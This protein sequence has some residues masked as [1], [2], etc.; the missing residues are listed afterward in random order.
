MRKLL[1]VLFLSVGIASLMGVSPKEGLAA[2]GE[3]SQKTDSKKQEEIRA[4][5][6]KKVLEK[7]A[8]L[9]GSSW[10][11]KIESQ[12]K[13]GD[14]LGSDT[15]IFQNERFR[16][17]RAG[18]NGYKSTNYTLTVQ[19]NGPTIWETMQTNE[20]GEVTFWR[21]EWQ[22]D[23]MTGVISRQIKD[24]NEEY[25]FS[26]SSRKEVPKASDVAEE[27]QKKT[28]GAK[29]SSEAKQAVLGGATVSATATSPVK[30]EKKKSWFA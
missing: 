26:S 2:W 16:S 24:T 4:A 3:K 7:K 9:N 11:V 6:R 13:K 23:V 28:T 29:V 20:D 19:E 8:E 5:W 25:Y 15:L 18:K 27:T 14:L 12:S 21:G 1:Y 17:E 10:A 22:K 30:P